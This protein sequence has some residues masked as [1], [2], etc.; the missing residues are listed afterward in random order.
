MQNNLRSNPSHQDD[1]TLA[2]TV[3]SPNSLKSVMDLRS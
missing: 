1:E 3:R 2:A